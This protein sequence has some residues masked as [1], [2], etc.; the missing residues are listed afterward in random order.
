LNVGNIFTLMKDFTYNGRI[1]YSPV[2]LAMAFIGGTWKMPILLAL[3]K[4]KLRYGELK[5]NI[6][7]I[8]DKMLYSQL[9]ELEKKGM[10][11]RKVY[12]EK[13]PRV[14][15]YVTSLGKRSMKVIDALNTF[16]EHLMSHK[17][18]KISIKK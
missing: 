11:E 6:P 3:R 4:G 2:E 15:Y 16:G 17:D 9:R 13:P 12:K 7:H 14:D 1:Y 10:I 8:T 5:S 18:I